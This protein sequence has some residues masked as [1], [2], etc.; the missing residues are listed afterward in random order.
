M[1]TAIAFTQ[2]SK[3]RFFAPQGWHIAPINVKFGM[4][5]QPTSTTR[6]TPPCQILTGQKCGNTAPESVKIWNFGHKFAPCT[7]Q[8]SFP[9]INPC[10]CQMNQG[11]AHS[12]GEHRPQF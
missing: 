10:L 5:E 7:T 12:P 9:A 3:N 6:S 11:P 8:L 2:W 4:G 1:I